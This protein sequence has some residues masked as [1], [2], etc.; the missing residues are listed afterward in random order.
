MFEESYYIINMKFIK[1][2][3]ENIYTDLNNLK[4]EESFNL[5]LILY[6]K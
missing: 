1:T 2:E 4:Y 5:F 6:F 3:K